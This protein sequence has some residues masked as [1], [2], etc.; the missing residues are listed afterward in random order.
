MGDYTN[1]S[2]EKRWLKYYSEQELDLKW[3]D[4]SLFDAISHVDSID[5]IAIRYLGLSITY[6]ELFDGIDKAAK[7][8]VKS[9]IRQ[10]D[11]VMLMLPT[12]PETIFS[13]YALNRIGAIAQFVDVR[14][15]P[16][17]LLDVALKTKPKMVMIM[18]FYLKEY[19]TVAKSLN[20][21]GTVILR[22]CDSMSRFFNFWFKT[23][24]FFNG[25]QRASKKLDNV[26]FWSDFIK[27]GNDCSEI[28]TVKTNGDT[29]AAIF[30]TSGTTGFPKSAIHTNSNLNNSAALKYKFMNNPVPGDTALSIIPAFTMFGFIYSVHMPLRYGM[31]LAIE[32]LFKSEQLPSLI[33]K[34]KPNHFFSVPSHWER[35]AEKK[36]D[37]DL[38]FI[39]TVYV[40]GEVLDPN[41]RSKINELFN[42]H[43]CNTQL[44]ADYGMTETGGTI[45]FMPQ[46]IPFEKTAINGYSGIPTPVCDLCIY[47][48]DNQ[49]ELNYNK[50]G[51]ICV[52]TPF[53]IKGYFDDPIETK[54]LFKKH[55]D[56]KTWLHTGDVGYISQDG[57]LFIK[58][59]RK[60]MIVRFDGTKLFPIEIESVIKPIPG[61]AECCVVP[62]SD[63]SHKYGQ[64][65][66]LFVVIEKS[67]DKTKTMKAVTKACTLKLPVYLQ[68]V[69][70]R[71]IDRLPRNA[72]GKT[73]YLKLIELL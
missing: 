9:G 46:S 36:L 34:Y 5:R 37:R 62:T 55:P 50:T 51:E 39:K 52:W 60:R 40:A 57:L 8:F 64:Q 30:Q 14:Y 18:T 24:E 23:G 63:K 53:V 3:S 35:L 19:E 29:V 67:F 45:S 61:I 58:G 47:D 65:P 26:L 33:H 4:D 13:F 49:Q 71:A 43:N 7:A 17:Q 68:P 21:T 66:Y 70:I 20:C 25:Q 54:C 2:V 15:T 28:P 44:C 10:G 59:R 73:D 72:M 27:K 12:L 56:G 69:G 48:N 42:K 41:L 31:T 22:G 1:P 38:S 32:P 16:Q 6:K 11:I